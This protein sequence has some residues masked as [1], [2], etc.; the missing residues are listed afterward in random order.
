MR[1]LLFGLLTSIALLAGCVTIHGPT[2]FTLSREDIERGIETDL[3]SMM[4]ALRG[5]DGRRPEV[6]VVHG[7]SGQSRARLRLSMP[8]DDARTAAHCSAAM[9]AWRWWCRA[10]R[11]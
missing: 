3:G 4:E 10:S 2:S 8:F 5:L 6:G 9:S 7:W 11:S 1:K